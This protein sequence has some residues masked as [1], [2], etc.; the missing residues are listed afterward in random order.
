MNTKFVIIDYSTGTIEII[1]YNNINWDCLE[2]EH[3]N[4]IESYLTEEHNF[5]SSNMHYLETDRLTIQYN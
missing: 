1:S 2:N 3:D 4:D 5:N